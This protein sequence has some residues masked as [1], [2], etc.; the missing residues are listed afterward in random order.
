MAKRGELTDAIQEK[1]KIFLG[2][3]I[4]V[5]ELRLYPY[6]SHVLQNDQYIDQR[7]INAKEREVLHTLD[8][9]GQIGRASC[10]E[11]VFKDV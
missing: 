7:K 5:A 1:A 8:D 11:R 2:R 6:I 9:E 4:T 3:E 10:R